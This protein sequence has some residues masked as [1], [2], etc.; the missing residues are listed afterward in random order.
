VATVKAS[1]YDPGLR[2][3]FTIT[4]HDRKAIVH[5]ETREILGVVGKDYKVH[6]YQQWLVDNTKDILDV[7]ELG[8]GSAG[9]LKKGAQAWVQIDLAETIEGPGGI[10]HR[11]FFLSSSSLDGQS[12][13]IYKV[14]TRLVRCDN[15]RELA[16]REDSPQVK[17]RHRSQS[18]GQ[19]G[20][21]RDR[22]GILY[23]LT[24]EMNAEL[25]QLLNVPVSDKQWEQ[26]ITAHI[27]RERP[28]ETGASQTRWDNRH[29]QLDD[30]YRT[31]ERCA[32][33]QGT[34]F[35]VQQTV[36][37]FGQHEAT[38]KGDVSG[39]PERQMAYT[40]SG[41]WARLDAETL[42]KLNLVLAA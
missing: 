6:D 13:T 29:D 5:P 21:I 4:D 28:T 27:G 11:P 22:L 25:D 12:S 10:D 8:I 40:V 1:G 32:Q 24:D 2:Q 20:S 36:S 42:G 3:H 14:G 35:G 41:Q 26:F 38:V 18:L 7:P 15:T 9:L 31:D 33:W 39:Q 23:Q 30:M 16:L 17:I 34:A 37:T 19:L